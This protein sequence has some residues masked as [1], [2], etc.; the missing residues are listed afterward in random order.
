MDALE[1]AAA[2][3]GNAVVVSWLAVIVSM[4]G[5]YMTGDQQFT[6][7]ATGC[8]LVV[9]VAV[10]GSLTVLP[11]L[12]AKLGRWVDRPRIPFLWRLTA[13][14]RQ[15]DGTAARPRFWSAVLRPALKHP[16]ATLVVSVGALVALAVPAFGMTL[17]LTGLQDVPRSTPVMQAYDRMTAAFPS[18][19]TQHVVVVKAPAAQAG[20]VAAA[21]AKLGD[22]AA[23]DPLFAHDQKPELT[24][25]P[26]K[27]VM[28]YAIG[29]PYVSGTK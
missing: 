23:A 16:V 20:A 1:N 28:E 13:T 14:R 3:S 21:L 9:A 12:L 5:M 18:T 17:K 10:I 24:V 7:I 29:T 22:R 11:G 8:I 25:S 2:T 4:A 26:D 27:T 15:A 19:G 6:A